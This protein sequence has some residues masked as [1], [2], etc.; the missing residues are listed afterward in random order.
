MQISTIL[1]AFVGTAPV[2]TAIYREGNTCTVTPQGAATIKRRSPA[3]EPAAAPGPQPE[4]VSDY[5]PEQN[6]AHE[7]YPTDRTDAPTPTSVIYNEVYPRP[8]PGSDG[9]RRYDRKAAA[10]SESIAA[11]RQASAL[12]SVA[13]VKALASAKAKGFA[14]HGSRGP[15]NARDTDILE[16]TEG[17]G[18]RATFDAA[19]PDDTPQILAAFKQCGHDGRIVFSEGTYNIRQ[20]M[21]TTD[22][23]NCDIDILGTFVWSGDNIQYW[24]SHSYSVAYAGRSTAWLLGGTNVSMRGYGKALFNGN[25][26]TWID[27]NHGQSNQNG[28]PISLTIWHGTNIFIDGITWRMSQF[29]HTFVA[30][31]QNVTMTNLDMDT[32]SSNSNSAVNTDGTDTWNSRD[33]VISNWTVKCGDDCISVKGNSTNVHVSNVV[34]YESGCACIGSIG[35]NSG[36]PDYVENVLFE[37]ITCHHSSNA[38]WIKT[39]P[40]TGHVRNVTFKDIVVDNVDQPIY[41]TPCIYSG[42]GCDSSRLTISDVTWK[43]VTGTSRYNV[44]VGIHCSSA[45]P[46][47]GFHFEDIDIKPVAGGTSKVLCSNIKNQATS[48]LTCTD[49]CPA[50][51]PQQLRGNR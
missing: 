24:L 37:N 17:T 48:G 19:A 7:Q 1:A 4:P 26:Q 28:R 50:N 14:G 40:G 35:S 31:S 30:H 20:V 25:G 43:N 15:L 22:L 36:Q 33:I 21:N 47:T 6:I 41:V 38:A 16:S 10:V 5:I 12:A 46:C 42:N 44:A 27:Q 18:E 39:Y 29:W 49:T 3:P 34:C 2:L 11:A 9:A 45:A 13:A 8:E 23:R 32:H 51:W